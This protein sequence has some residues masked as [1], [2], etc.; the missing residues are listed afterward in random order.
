VQRVAEEP[1]FS[2][3]R[4]YVGHGIGRS[5]HEEPQCPQLRN[6]RY[7]PVLEGG[8]VFAIEPMVNAGGVEVESLPDG[9]TVV[10]G[11]I[12]LGALRAHGCGDRERP[13]GPLVLTHE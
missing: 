3:V 12:A 6:R 1:G 10:T 11:R 4:E 5:M 13:F 7:R 9:W 2:V 8:M